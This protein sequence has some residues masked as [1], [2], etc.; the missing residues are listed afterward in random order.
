MGVALHL[1]AVKVTIYCG[2]ECKAFPAH[3]IGRLWKFQLSEVNESVR[4]GGA[5]DGTDSVEKMNLMVEGME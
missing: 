2:R 1:G 4:V 3:K 5:D